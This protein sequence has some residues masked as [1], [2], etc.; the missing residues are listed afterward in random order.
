MS[1]RVLVTNDDGIDAKGLRVLTATLVAH[2]YTPLVVA[3]D[4]DYS[5]ASGSL[6]SL[7]SRPDALDRSEIR[8][9]ERT[10][11]EAPGVE[12]YAI[13]GPPALCALLAIRGAFGPMPDLVTSGINFGLNAGPAVTHSGTVNAA[14]TTSKAGIP[15]LAIS[16]H[17]SPEEPD[18]MRYDT[19]AEVAM[20]V[21]AEQAI[22][23]TPLVSLNVPRCDLSDV[24]GIRSAPLAETFRW[25]SFVEPAAD[26]VIT[27]TFEQTDEALVPGTDTDLV[28]QGWATISALV[29]ISAIE[30]DDLATA[31]TKAGATEPAA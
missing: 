25:R 26:G 31:A 15:S 23:G 12:A 9:E 16:A 18:E 29:P 3:P 14:L 7:T 10:L 11:E 21:L 22:A 30:C 13:D 24:K 5:G 28:D 4:Q 6:L 17:F 2:G 19:A 27:R 1:K 20:W 8:Y